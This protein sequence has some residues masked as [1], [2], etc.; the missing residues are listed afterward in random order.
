VKKI[1]FLSDTYPPDLCG[2][3]DYVAILGERL[4][5]SYEIHIITRKDKLTGT[6]H[7]GALTVHPILSGKTYI[8]GAIQR[9]QC[10]Q[11]HVLDVQLSYSSASQL[12]QQ[13]LVTVINSLLLKSMAYPIKLCLTIHEL[14]TYLLDCPTWKRK[15]YRRLRDYGQTRFYDYY[16]CTSQSYLDYLKRTS[17]KTFLPNFSNIPSMRSHNLINTKSIIFFGTIGPRKNIDLLCHL[18][19]QLNRLDPK[20]H[21]YFVGGIVTGYEHPF[22]QLLGTLPTGSCS[23]LGHLETGEM[24]KVLDVCSYAIFPFSVSD[25]NAS[26]LA[27]LVNSLVVIACCD[28]LPFYAT[29]G[30]N[31]YGVSDMT[32][33]SIEAIISATFG[34]RTYYPKNE[35]LIA[36]HLEQRQ[37]V[38]Q[39]L[40]AS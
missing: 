4:A 31:F 35:D 26:V 25:K 1:V 19:G 30:D 38:Y 5:S 33:A 9:I 10:I 28:R 14:S 22:L 27:M 11:P 7:H 37:T 40:L 21:L 23:N 20:I 32:V 12:H 29:Q 34:K 6:N 18:F 3:A 39:Q 13:N 16:F 15:L 24:G 8:F 2:V 17:R 36:Q